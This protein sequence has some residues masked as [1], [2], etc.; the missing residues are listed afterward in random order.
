MP[1]GSNGVKN[2][3]YKIGMLGH[4]FMGKTHS[5]ALSRIPLFFEDAPEIELEF[6][7]GIPEE[8]V[9]KASK[10]YG[11]NRYTT[12][13]DEVVEEDDIDIIA[14]LTPN[15]L[16]SEPSIK[17]LENGKSVFCEKPLANTLENARKMTK[18]AEKSDGEAGIS[19]V[20][21]FV[22]AIR[23]AKQMIDEGLLGEIH[24]F[25]GLYLQ[26]WLVDPEAPWTWRVDEESAGS[27]SLG[28]LGAHSIDLARYLVGDIESVSGHL[29][30]FVDERPLPEEEGT[31]PVTVDDAYS[32]QAEFENGAMGLFE[33]SRFSTGYKNDN[34]I[35]IHGSD[36]AIRFSLESINELEIYDR[37]DDEGGFK[38]ILV[39][40]PEHPFIEAWWPPG[41][42]IGWEHAFVHEW[43][44]FLTAISKGEE[45]HPNFKDGLRVQEVLEA[46]MRSAEERKWVKVR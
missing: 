35:E 10:R 4:G 5:N 16:H 21:R 12:D 41:H 32:M 3:T 19:F 36:G 37:S 15:F 23:L 33:A 14:N 46:A 43:V 8:G 2:M 20:Y 30:T 45:Y 40:N 18:A 29:K 7:A 38:T 25:R 26:D 17:A 28:D 9:S 44:S 11:F 34:K 6:I 42:V 24:H 22:P 1:I 31:K 39:T 13:L 27:G